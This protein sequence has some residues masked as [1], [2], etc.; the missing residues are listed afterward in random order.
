M[1]T[2]QKTLTDEERKR[3]RQALAKQLLERK[4][5]AKEELQNDI[6]NPVYQEVV[7]VLRQ[8]QSLSNGKPR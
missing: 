6:Q 4:K 5:T 2:L 1:A 7:K 3:N 8:K